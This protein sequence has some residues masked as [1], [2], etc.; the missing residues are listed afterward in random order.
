MENNKNNPIVVD[1]PLRGEWTTPNTP[2]YK[3]PSHG[4]DQLGQRFAYDFMQIDW[5]TDKGFKFF[6]K[7]MFSYY[8]KGISLQK[9]FGWSQPFYAPFQGEI[10]DMADGHR[11]RD[12]V[13]FIRDLFIVLKNAFT[14]SGNSNH[15]LIPAIGNYII[16]KGKNDIYAFFAHARCGTIEV[17][18]GDI[19]ET[20]QPMAEVGHSGNSTAPHLHFHLM[21]SLDLF[22]AKG[23]NCCFRV[24]E[25]YTETGWEKVEK[26]IPNFRE[27]IRVI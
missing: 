2:G 9:C 11:E 21:D 12:P 1:F 3:I 23:V 16:L 26:G 7:S 14:L 22:T 19:V 6:D 5:C 17:K 10:V 18:I 8:M 27:R 24:Y 13:Y 15:D 25:T 20:G 4:T